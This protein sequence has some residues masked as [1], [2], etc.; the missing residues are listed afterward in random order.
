[1]FTPAVVSKL[2][3]LFPVIYFNAKDV[4]CFINLHKFGYTPGALEYLLLDPTTAET[5]DLAATGSETSN[6]QDEEKILDRNSIGGQPS[7]I[8]E[9]LGIIDEAAE[10][11]PSRCPLLACPQQ[12]VQRISLFVLVMTA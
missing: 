6:K 11:H 7:M 1:M 5:E 9:L 8:S 4:R 12:D 2:I 10:P 3:K